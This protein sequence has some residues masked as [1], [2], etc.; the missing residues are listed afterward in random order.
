MGCEPRDIIRAAGIVNA[1]ISDGPGLRLTVF[2]QGCER[3]CPGC[4]N[5]DTHDLNGGYDL[6]IS[7]IVEL[8]KQNKLLD[9]VTLSGGEPF[10]QPAALCALAREIKALGGNVVTY[11]GYTF[12]ELL[13]KDDCRELLALTDILIDGP[14]ELAQRTLELPFRGSANQRALDV[15]RSL[16]AG[17][18][19]E[20]NL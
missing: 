13:K 8:Y 20:K 18:A 12:E 9:G 1:S 2:A 7:D 3:D 11:T 5:P 15:V 17:E 14:F 4:H 19:A 16:A 6:N 10:L